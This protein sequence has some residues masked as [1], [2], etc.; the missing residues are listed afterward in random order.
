MR[1]SIFLILLFFITSCSDNSSKK[2][3]KVYIDDVVKIDLPKEK[4][5][6]IEGLIFKKI[7][8]KIFYNFQNQTILV[9]TNDKSVS[10]NQITEL[11]KLK[12]KFYIIKNQEIIEHFQ[13]KI[14]PTIIIIKNNIPKKYEGFIPYEVLKFELK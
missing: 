14:F 10:N 5:I 2:E 1:F 8:N 4:N 11:K 12:H 3:K 6:N 7:D 9:F 13:V